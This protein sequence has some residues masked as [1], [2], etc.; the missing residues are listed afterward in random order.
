MGSSEEV[1]D[2]DGC[3]FGGTVA[4]GLEVFGNRRGAEG[5]EGRESAS[6]GVDPLPGVPALDGDVLGV[7]DADLGDE[8]AVLVQVAGTEG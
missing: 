6:A 7:L 3:S 8:V 4:V 5:E 1:R 2:G